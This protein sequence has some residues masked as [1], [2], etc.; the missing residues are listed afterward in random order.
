MKA[1]FLSERLRTVGE[2]KR[3]LTVL[4]DD[5]PVF[6]VDVDCTGHDYA[7]HNYAVVKCVTDQDSAHLGRVYLGHLEQH[8]HQHGTAVTP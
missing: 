1:V 8:E 4:A 7:A 6:A 2:L 5:V 3:A